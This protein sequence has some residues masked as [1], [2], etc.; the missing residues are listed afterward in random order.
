MFWPFK[1]RLR[2]LAECLHCGEFTQI[3][4]EEA[5]FV[6]A[7][8]FYLCTACGEVLAIQAEEMQRWLEELERKTIW[9]AN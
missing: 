5:N 1:I 3:S 8:G 2:Y 7:N 9:P 6:E 4:R